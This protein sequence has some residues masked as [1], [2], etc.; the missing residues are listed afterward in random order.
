MQRHEEDAG[1]ISGKDIIQSTS[2]IDY[3]FI[4]HVPEDVGSPAQCKG[5]STCAHTLNVL[6]A[7]ST[8]ESKLGE[9]SERSRRPELTSP[10]Y[11]LPVTSL[12]HIRTDDFSPGCYNKSTAE[13]VIPGTAPSSA[14]TGISRETTTLCWSFP[15]SQFTDKSMRQVNHV[16]VQ[17][18]THRQDK[19]LCELKRKLTRPGF[20]VGLQN[21]SL[22]SLLS[23]SFLWFLE[24]IWPKTQTER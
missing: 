14:L 6:G 2:F 3:Y 1:D 19:F 24:L 18:P 12:A 15:V 9:Q 10:Q 13:V 21:I 20:F 11:N 17:S 5:D 8:T 7:Q 22:F 23:A 4:A 16:H